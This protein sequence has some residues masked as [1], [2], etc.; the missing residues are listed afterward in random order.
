MKNVLYVPL[1][2]RPVNLDDVIMLGQS[3]GLNVIAPEPNDIA[4]RPDSLAAYTGMTLNFTCCPKFGNPANIRRFILGH[5]S[6]VDGFLISADML[7]YGGLIASRRLQANAGGPYPFFD[8]IA[9]GLLDVIRLVKQRF[10]AKP[11]YVMDTVMR[12]A[13]TVY[14]EG[15]SLAA[16]NESREFMGQPRRSFTNFEEILNGYDLSPTSS[17]G[18]TVAFDKERYYNARRRKFKTNVYILDQLVR[19]GYIDFLAIGVD[20]ASIQGVQSNEIAFLETFVDHWLEP[21]ESRHKR[22]VILPDADGLGHSL[23]AR[24]ANALYRGEGAKTRYALRYFGPEGTTIVNPYEYINVHENILRHIE[25]AGGQLADVSPDAEII[26]VTASDQAMA[27]ANRIEC[28]AKQHIPSCVIDFS[29]PYS[30]D[31]AV[32]EA[33]LGTPYTGRLL[34]YSGW[35][36]AGNRIGIALGMTQARYVYLLAERKGHPAAAVNAH[37]SLLFKRF[38]KDYYYKTLTV[39]DIR[40][41]AQARS[42]FTNV[43]AD[44][45]LR[46]FTSAKDYNA[47]LRLLQE[48]MEE[49][50]QVLSTKPAFGIG[51]F[52]PSYDVKDICGSVWELARYISVSFAKE[53]PGFPWGRAFEITLKPYVR[54]R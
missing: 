17:Y 9:T 41:E 45:H 43:S 51:T 23:M 5:A 11:L 3:S 14:V 50:L 39:G 20:D 15:L 25:V 16:Y 32:S 34:G 8:P 1:D 44:Q 27:A 26:A 29:N 6:L 35:N 13:T 52:Q 36:T 12:L 33:L 21:Q 38:L 24:M 4:N 22:V 30:S 49:N 19:N 7:V 42:L 47:I 31:P 10:P 2:D 53:Q 46:L 54:L 28:N 37:G 40:Q 48:R 18:D